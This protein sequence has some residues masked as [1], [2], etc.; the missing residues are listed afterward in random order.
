TAALYFN[1]HW[2]KQWKDGVEH[3]MGELLHWDKQERA[4]QRERLEK[5]VHDALTPVR[6]EV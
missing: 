5:A 2:V 6:K 3:T 4:K 1:I